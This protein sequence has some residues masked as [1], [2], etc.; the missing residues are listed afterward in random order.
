MGFR[1]RRSD[2]KKKTFADFS[3]AAKKS[4]CDYIIVTDVFGSTIKND[5]LNCRMVM[6]ESVYRRDGTLATMQSASTLTKHMTPIEAVM[7]LHEKCREERERVLSAPIAKRTYGK[8]AG[9]L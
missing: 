5:R 9:N 8:G 6:E 7:Y 1:E 3:A 2:K 4:G